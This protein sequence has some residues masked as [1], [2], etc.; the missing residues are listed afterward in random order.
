MDQLTHA[1]QMSQILKEGV[2]AIQSFGDAIRQ[3]SG[4]QAGMGALRQYVNSPQWQQDRAAFLAGQLPG[5]D[6]SLFDRELLDFLLK[7][8][9]NLMHFLE[10]WANT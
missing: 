3:F 1:Q 5:V 8:N 10:L 2:T 6:G 4:M 9:E 7:E